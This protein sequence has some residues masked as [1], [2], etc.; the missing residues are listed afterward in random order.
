MSL[1][2]CLPFISLKRYCQKMSKVGVQKNYIKENGQK[3]GLPIKGG[4]KPSA[5]YESTERP[6]DILPQRTRISFYKTFIY[7]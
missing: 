3:G 4:F 1:F 7:K 5:N 2:L 6:T